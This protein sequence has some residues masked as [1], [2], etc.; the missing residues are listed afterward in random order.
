M[1]TTEDRSRVIAREADDAAV[2]GRRIDSIKHV[3]LRLD[4]SRLRR[5]HRELAQRLARELGVAVTWRAGQGS[6]AVPSSVETLFALERLVYRVPGPR[7]SG[8]LGP[9]K[10]DLVGAAAQPPDLIIDLT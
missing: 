1:L 4:P 5:F 3:A 8:R 9:D 10:L 2:H 7:L 6:A